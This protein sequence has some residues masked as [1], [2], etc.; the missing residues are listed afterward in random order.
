MAGLDRRILKRSSFGVSTL[1]SV[2]SCDSGLTTSTW[3]ED[4]TRK[5]KKIGAKPIRGFDH[6]QS[7]KVVAEMMI[8]ASG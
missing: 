6:D 8:T 3:L 7:L 1:A 4:L 5:K 2:E